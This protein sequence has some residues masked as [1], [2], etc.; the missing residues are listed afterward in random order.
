[1]SLLGKG[2]V[3]IWHDI[4][5]VGRAQ[6]YDW[7]GNEHMPERVAIPGFLRGR[8]YVA[9]EADLEFFNL[10]ETRSTDVL[11]GAAYR[12]RLENPTA[13]TTD[14]VRHFRSVARALCH[15][16]WTGGAGE[17][18]LVTT[19]RYD[20]EAGRED[21]HAGALERE[22]LA[23]LL[24]DGSLAAAHVLV[25]DLEAS[26]VDTAER[27]LR[28]AKNAVPHRVL[29]VEGWGDREPF[30]ALCRGRIEAGLGDCNACGE[31]RR[32]LYRLQTTTLRSAT[33]DG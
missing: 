32:G 2:A 18:G 17:G 14:T 33:T 27:R 13:W 30:D 16:E 20:V 25:A 11:S 23:P 5:A 24:G 1:M 8:R 21:T 22:V 6:F 19:W 3:A 4:A 26:S 12:D 10:Y 7:H 15:V 28:D 29:V 9:L 31:V